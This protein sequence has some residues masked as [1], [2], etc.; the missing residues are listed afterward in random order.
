MNTAEAERCFST[1]KRV[2]TFL[3]NSMSNDRLNALAML[4]INRDFV[5]EIPNFDEKVLEQFVA[6]KNSYKLK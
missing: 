4:A 3:R 2:K 1:L 5:L 6:I